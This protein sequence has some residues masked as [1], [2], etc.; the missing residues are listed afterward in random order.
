MKLKHLIHTIAVGSLLVTSGCTKDFAEINSNP[1]IITRD[2]VT[3]ALL[4]PQVQKGFTFEILNH[5]VI[6]EYSGYY[7]NG[8]SGNIFQQRD[9][10]NPHN[11]FFRN[12]LINIS[13]VIRL[14]ANNPLQKNM[15]SQARIT[16]A[17]IY[18]VLTDLY[19][20]LPYTEALKSIEETILQPKYDTQ[21]FIYTSLLNE[22]KEATEALE[23]NSA[24][25]SFGTA[26]LWLK[27]NVDNWRR[28][29]NSLR[30]RMAMR[31]R[32][33][34][35]TLA[36]QHINDV[37]T[38][39]LM[40]ANTHNVALATL[41]DG[42]SGNVNTFYTRNS[43]SPNLMVVS[44][45]LTDN[46]KKLND[47]RLPLFAREA[48]VP[49]AGY[50]GV[51]LQVGPGQSE[52]YQNDSTARMQTTFLQQVFTIVVMNAAE[53]TLFRAEA[54]NAG[55]TSENAQA[56]FETGIQLAMSQYGVSSGNITT[57]LAS[58]SGILSGTEE[59]RMEQIIVQKWLAT[60]YN[61]F[62][63]YAEFR[64][65]GYPRIWTGSNLGDTNGQIPRRLTYPIAESLRNGV[66]YAEAVSRLNGGDVLT[67]KIW[68]DKKPGVPFAHPRQGMFPPEF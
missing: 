40:T 12:Y 33:A 63:G 29:G 56:M 36:A 18:Q 5:G 2:V 14:T 26:D 50:R 58:P 23:N 42:N 25:L 53:V 24:Q 48:L 6:S 15:N 37:I 7:K 46:L 13:E 39:P 54:A 10:A 64:R 9:W 49:E 59:E 28:F 45:T 67:A 4:F 16:K 22:V 43:T 35:P 51:P 20:D 68:W 1:L 21:E 55:I 65:T 61:T 8:A 3:P 60:Y 44:F 41:N 66:N 17:L 34:N 52:R 27:G 31:I 30:L 19:G 62:E 38:K 47:P 57:Y 32:Y 11:T